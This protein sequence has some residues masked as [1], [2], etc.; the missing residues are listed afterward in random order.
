MVFPLYDYAKLESKF[1][2]LKQQAKN[3]LKRERKYARQQ[4]KLKENRSLK[5]DQVLLK[6]KYLL[7]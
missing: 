1:R 7:R 6:H 4:Q 5:K 2:L 3:E